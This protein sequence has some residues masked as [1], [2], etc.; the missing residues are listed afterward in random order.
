MAVAAQSRKR[1]PEVLTEQEVRALIGACSNR[2]PTGIR[3]RALIAV[4]WRCGL[5]L[6]EALA[7][8]PRDADL[9]AGALRVRHGKGD[10]SRTVGLDDGTQA[11]LAR[12]LDRRQRLGVNG[13]RRLFCKLDGGPLDQSYVRHLLRRLAAKAGIERRVHPHGLRHSYA[14]ELA[15]EG[16]PMNVLR[17]A[18]G[19]STL[20]T[21]DRYLRDVAPVHVIETM[22]RREWQ[23]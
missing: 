23:L 22:R 15:R 8:E 13:R 5:R 16:V 10:R 9:H 1:P 21:T 20:A 19:H 18:L 4:L 14:A 17:D 7:L 12:W 3:N 6:G 2:A 11:L